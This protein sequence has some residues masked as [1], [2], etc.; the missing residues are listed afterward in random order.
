MPNWDFQWQ[1]FYFLE[2]P[3]Y[4]LS[5]DQLRLRCGFDT[6]SRDAPV[7]WGEGTSDEMCLLGLYVTLN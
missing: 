1:Q 5:T 4:I 6:S 3:I 7:R 2:D